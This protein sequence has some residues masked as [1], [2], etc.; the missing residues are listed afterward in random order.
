M[1]NELLCEFLNIADSYFIGKDVDTTKIN[2]ET[3]IKGNCRNGSCKT[4]W[5]SINA[6]TVYILILFRKSIDKDK[7]NDYDECFLLWLS[8][9][10]FKIHNES[11]DKNQ[12]ITLNEAYDKY[13]KKHKVIMD[14]WPLL[15]N[16]KGLKNAKLKDMS[17]FYKLLNKICIT[18]SDYNDNGAESNNITKNSK[19]CSNQYMMLHNRFSGCKSYLDLLN[20][21][22]YIYDKFRNPAMKE[23]KKKNLLSTLQPL[24][25]KDGIEIRSSRVFKPYDFNNP[26]CQSKK[27]KSPRPPKTDPS[28]LLFFSKEEPPPQ[29]LNQLKDSQHKTPPSSQNSNALPKTKTEKS[30]SSSVQDASKINPKTSDNSEGNTR[31]GSGDTGS[32]NSG[33]GNVDGRLNDQVG[34]GVKNMND[35]VKEPEAPSDGKGSQVSKA[36]GTNGESVGTDIGKGGPEDGPGV[37]SG[38]LDNGQCIKD[39]KPGSSNSEIRNTGGKS[40]DKDSAGNTEDKKN[41][42]TDQS[43]TQ[44]NSVKQHKGLSIS[45]GSIDGV[46]GSTKHKES[47]NNSMEKHQRHDSLESNPKEKPQDS[48]KETRQLQEPEQ[49]QPQPS[50]QPKDNQHETS[51]PSVSQTG[52]TNEQ[53]TSDIPPKGPSSE[54]KD[55]DDDTENRKSP[56]SDSKDHGQTPVINKRDSNDGPG[57]GTRGTSSVSGGQISNG[58]QRGANTSQQG[59]SGGSGHGTG[60]QGSSSHQGGDTGGDKGSQDGSDRKEGKPPTSNDPSPTQKDLNQQNS[61]DTS[62]TPKDPQI[63]Q[64]QEQR[65]SH[66][67]SGNQNSDRTDQEEPQKPVI[68]PVIKKENIRTELKGNGI[69]GID[70]GN[71]LKKYKKNVISIIVILIPITLTI[72]YKYLSSGWRKELTRKKNMKKVI[73]SIGGKKQIQIIIKSSNQKKNTKKSINSIYK[74]KFPSLNIY[75]LMQADPIPFINLFFLLIFFVYK[76]KEN[77]LEL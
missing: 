51:Q 73:N 4:N 43:I 47:T 50:E 13:L 25:T 45:G 33:S 38:G 63:S 71:V 40:S 30:S 65:T 59:K 42:Q 7:Y 2:E 29:P 74:E 62:Q 75:K 41:L 39:S 57:G 76:R 20:K 64:T 6:L 53:R 48:Q 28:V 77:F 31:E 66:D 15:D 56:Q 46:D 32:S 22:K 67:T 52:L 19:E 8:D 24:K 60:N 17:E 68:T 18:I 49:Q 27:K 70:D 35:G 11:K 61:S 37:G 1:E 10:L 16:I 26:Q 69:T 55:P 54:Q 14:H 21:L 36:D 9:K 34:S 58:S 23:I 12:N 5:N 72:L 3:N 44:G